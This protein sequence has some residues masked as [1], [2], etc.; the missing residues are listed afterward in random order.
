M[1]SKNNIPLNKIYGST[2]TLT[3]SKKKMNTLSLGVFNVVSR[4]AP[5]ISNLKPPTINFYI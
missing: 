1:I 4:N 3:Y 2:Y 5:P